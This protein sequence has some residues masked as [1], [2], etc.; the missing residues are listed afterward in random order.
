MNTRAHGFLWLLVAVQVAIPASYYLRKSDLDDERFAWRM[1]SAVRVKRCTVELFE[2][3]SAGEHP[4]DLEK[5]LHSSWRSAL[6]RGR[7]RVI[8]H[9][10]AEHCERTAAERLEFLRSCR[11]ADGK[12]LPSE[13]RSWECTRSSGREEGRP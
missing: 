6:A 9:F 4:V 12:E 5:A 7:T 8:Q 1:F 2:V 11:D 3:G 10:L 13:R